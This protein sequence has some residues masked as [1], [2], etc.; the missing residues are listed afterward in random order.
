MSFREHKRGR[1]TSKV[2]G[3]WVF[4]FGWRGTRGT[5]IYV[6]V[7]GN[8]SAPCRLRLLWWEIVAAAVTY[9]FAALKDYPQN[10]V[11]FGRNGVEGGGCFFGAALLLLGMKLLLQVTFLIIFQSTYIYIYIC[12]HT[13]IHMKR[14]GHFSFLVALACLHSPPSIYLFRNPH[15]LTLAISF[16]ASWLVDTFLKINH[17]QHIK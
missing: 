10:R 8:V 6:R 17:A 9:A 3:I 2:G 12:A 4:F 14:K 13:Y 15:T 5:G 1:Q 11:E 16:A 7:Y